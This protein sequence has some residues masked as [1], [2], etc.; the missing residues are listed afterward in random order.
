MLCRELGGVGS[1]RLPDIEILQ[2]ALIG[3]EAQHRKIAEIQSQLGGRTQHVA[4]W[5]RDR[6]RSGGKNGGRPRKLAPIHAVPGGGTGRVG[7]TRRDVRDPH[8]R[9]RPLRGAP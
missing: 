3:Y 6:R 7:G 1:T 9:T 2:M 4:A 8:R 5:E